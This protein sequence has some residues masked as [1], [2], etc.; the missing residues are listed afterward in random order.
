MPLKQTTIVLVRKDSC[1]TQSKSCH[2]ARR[3]C[4]VWTCGAWHE[5]NLH[6][7]P[8]VCKEAKRPP[9]FHS[10]LSR[11]WSS[12][13]TSKTVSPLSSFG[14]AP[15]GKEA[16]TEGSTDGCDRARGV[17]IHA[18]DPCCTQMFAHHDDRRFVQTSWFEDVEEKGKTA[19]N[20]LKAIFNQCSRS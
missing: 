8:W 19:T 13:R 5:R 16:A 10:P 15:K 17:L 1:E 20:M 3:K 12:D 6:R 7:V 2:E 4:I 11:F 14:M 18:T 9:P